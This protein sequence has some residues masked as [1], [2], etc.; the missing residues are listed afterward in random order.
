MGR[1]LQTRRPTPPG[2]AV[3]GARRKTS[4]AEVEPPQVR[5]ASRDKKADDQRAACL[6]VSTCILGRVDVLLQSCCAN[7]DVEW[8]GLY[9]SNNE[10]GLRVPSR[11]R[12]CGYRNRNWKPETLAGLSSSKVDPAKLQDG[13]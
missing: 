11:G 5:R 13:G 4:A 10:R 6:G 8:V 3:A 2:Y 1:V 7:N 9:A 12:W